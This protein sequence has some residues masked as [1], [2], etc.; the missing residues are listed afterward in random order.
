MKTFALV[1]AIALA[2]PAA[3]QVVPD[4]FPDADEPLIDRTRRD[5][6]ERHRPFLSGL[7]TSSSFAA[8]PQV[9][10]PVLYGAAVVDG[11]Y[12]FDSGDAIALQAVV[13]SPLDRAFFQDP[14]SDRLAGAF[15]LEGV[16]GL[17]RFAAPGSILERAEVGLAV[18]LTAYDV[19]SDGPDGADLYGDTP[20]TLVTPFVSVS[21][22]VA[23]PL[24]PTLSVPVGFRIG[25]EIGAAGRRAPFVGLS[26]GLRRIFADEARMVL[27]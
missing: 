6:V 8:G 2:L 1:L 25:Q 21:P 24:T 22:R 5:L 4:E 7:Y 14:A 26:V 16:V 20:G 19:A 23:L 15:G 12:R 27:E 10:E 13:Q 17:R 3:A 11:G 9:G 18:G